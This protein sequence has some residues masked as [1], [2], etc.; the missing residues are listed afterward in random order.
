M[1]EDKSIRRKRRL[2]VAVVFLL[3]AS[4]AFL[5]GYFFN[6]DVTDYSDSPQKPKSANLQIPDS[7]IN[8]TA[9][10]KPYEEVHADS[11]S[12]IEPDMQESSLDIPNTQLIFRTYYNSC[13]H[14]SEKAV[15]TAEDEVDM[16]EGQLEAKY[17]GWDVT[18]FSPPVVELSRRINTYCPRHYIIGVADGFIAVYVYDEN[19]QKVLQEKT[20][21][22]VKTLT[23]ED[24]RALSSG[25]VTD[26]EEQKEQT[27]E[28]FSN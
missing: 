6:T 26:T 4:A 24:Q 7:L 19:G 20:D 22:S 1:F 11:S 16:D 15:K 3:L 10:R 14:T 8:P 21:I 2:L 18:G 5:I 23:P 27:I 17:P 13:D 12:Q 9:D 28:G 25:I